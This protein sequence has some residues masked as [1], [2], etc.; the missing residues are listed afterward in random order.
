VGWSP[1]GRLFVTRGSVTT[2]PMKVDL[3]D[4]ATGSSTHYRDLAPADITGVNSLFGL[5]IAANGAY[6]YSYYRDLS[7]LFLVEGIR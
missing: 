6:V 5:R 3:V 2:I 4:P 7:T 1:D